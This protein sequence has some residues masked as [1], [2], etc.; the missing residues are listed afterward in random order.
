MLFLRPL[1]LT[2]K[3]A[4]IAGDIN[5]ALII[6]ENYSENF[7]AG[8]TAKV[9]LVFDS[10]RQFCNGGHQSRAKSARRIW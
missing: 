2:L 4:V 10:T 8:E 5:V 6:P 7:S 9:Q 3:S 1:L